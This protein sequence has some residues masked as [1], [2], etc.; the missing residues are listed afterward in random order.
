MVK[1]DEATVTRQGQISIPKAIREK[2]HLEKGAKLV[3]LEDERGE[4]L[5][6]EAEVPLEFTREQWAEFLA[7]SEKEPVTRVRG[8]K[9]ALAYLDRMM[10]KK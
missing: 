5:I 8:K 10:A 7:R 9:A 3:F 2:L 6:R 1:L 4:I